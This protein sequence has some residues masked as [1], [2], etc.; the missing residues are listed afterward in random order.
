[1][2]RGRVHAA[3]V[4][5]FDPRRIAWVDGLRGIAALWVLLSHVQILSGLRNVPLLSWGSLAVDLFMMLS[6][7]LM[8][9]NFLLRES[10][11]P[12]DSGTTLI[13]FWAR[14]FFRIAPIYY[15]L[16]VVALLVG[17][18][19]G[20][21]RDAIAHVWPATAT[22]GYRYTDQSAANL[23][24]HLS[25]L[26]GALPEY[27]FRTPLPDWSI[28]LEMQFY[29][30]FPFAMLAMRRFGF[31]VVGVILSL[32]G[33]TVVQA[34]PAFFGRYEM[35]SFLPMK[36]YMFIVGMWLGIGRMKGALRAGLVAA[37]AVAALVGF[38]EGSDEAVA[39]VLMI[40]SMYY[41]MNDGSL[42][43]TFVDRWVTR[44]VRL[45][46]MSKVA[47]FLGD[48]SYCVYLLHLLVLLPVAAFLASNSAY[49]ALPAPVRFS[50]VLSIVL[51]IVL[52]SAWAL[53][54]TVEQGGIRMGKA[55]VAHAKRRISAAAS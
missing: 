25:F 30:F 22:S 36:L 51:P 3:D 40:G 32:I 26:F 19:M 2:A 48:T 38:K 46:F 41:L 44:K 43:T 20:A 14:R 8:A 7:F 49:V 33:L 6:G 52:L 54:H 45:L 11:E 34:A 39:R 42:P 55:V 31:I 17:P 1:M 10:E 37:L 13:A 53:Y 35:P 50:L 15:L 4:D 21:C 12:W 9:H 27:A 5:A 47:K 28:G 16:L 23:F 24:L 18:Y 29:L